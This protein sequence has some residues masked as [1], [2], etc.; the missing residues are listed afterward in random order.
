ME[1]VVISGQIRYIGPGSD[2]TIEVIT[3]PEYGSRGLVVRFRQGRRFK[4]GRQSSQPL[5]IIAT[6]AFLLSQLSDLWWGS[7]LLEQE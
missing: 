6:A 1:H 3:E 5:A 7:R 4:H 2:R